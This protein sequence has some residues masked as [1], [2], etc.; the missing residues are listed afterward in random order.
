MAAEPNEN[1]RPKIS[2][3][4][5]EIAFSGPAIYTNKFYVTV[6][7]AHARIAF[8]EARK[9]GDPQFRSAVS[10][11]LED[12]FK[13]RDIINRLSARMKVIEVPVPEGG[14]DNG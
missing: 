1:E 10:M 12:L 8:T 9:E 13:L 3:R 2:E 14:G 4:E 7:G 6:G 11:T 5:M